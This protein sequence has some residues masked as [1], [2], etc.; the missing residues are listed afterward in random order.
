MSTHQLTNLVVKRKCSVDSVRAVGR[1]A[2]LR[3]AW[4]KA[5]QHGC[6]TW[7]SAVGAFDPKIGRRFA[8]RQDMI[9]VAFDAGSKAN[10][11]K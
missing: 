4:E 7:G 10:M 11:N 5:R 1:E 9:A 2:H 6:R 3:P 8:S